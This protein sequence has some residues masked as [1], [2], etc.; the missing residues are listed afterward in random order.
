MKKCPNLRNSKMQVVKNRYVAVAILAVMVSGCSVPR[1]GPYSSTIADASDAQVGGMRVV[2]VTGPQSVEW[3]EPTQ[4]SESLRRAG[5]ANSYSLGAGDLLSIQVWEEAISPD[6]DGSVGDA[7][8]SLPRAEIDE[9]GEVFVPFAGRVRALGSSVSEFQE[10]LTNALAAKL[11]NPQVS[12]ARVESES[13]KVNVIGKVGTNGPVA[14][15]A[16]NRSILDVL[17]RAG[18][19]TE[20]PD[21]ST[22][23]L[24]RGNASETLWLSDIYADRSNDVALRAG[25]T[26]LVERDKRNFV[27]LG[28]VNDQTVVPFPARRVS[29]LRALAEA[30]GLNDNLA[31]PTGIFIFR[32]GARPDSAIYLLNLD[33]PDGMLLADG[34][35]IADG[36]MI[37]ATNA[38]MTTWLK[39]VGA[40]TPAIGLAG[41]VY[42]I[43][44]S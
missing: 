12:V 40:I 27:V 31:D 1:S 38:P 24:M 26:V 29:A 17:T 8:I 28:A 23:T 36:D 13:T 44:G 18:G 39:I 22:V 2:E 11:I 19:A 34:F 14:L 10:T 16:S 21:V 6:A 42:A 9:R 37:Y 33:R 15:N 35:E 20:E 43:G 32:P 4:F 3:T 7:S 30:D 41:S 25:D 5:P